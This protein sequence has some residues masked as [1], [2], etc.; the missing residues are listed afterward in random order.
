MGALFGLSVLIFDEFQNNAV[1]LRHCLVGEG[2]TVHAVS[3]RSAALMLVRRKRI[4]FVFMDIV[5]EAGSAALINEL[6]LRKIPLMF[7]GGEPPMGA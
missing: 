2:A 7:T 6:H 5:S 4:D 1:H 3:A